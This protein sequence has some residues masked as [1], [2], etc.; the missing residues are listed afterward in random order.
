MQL[1]EIKKIGQSFAIGSEICFC[2]P[3]GNGL[4]N[5]TYLVT[6]KDKTRYTLQKI[7]TAVFQNPEGL[8]KN[9]VGVT[10]YL[11]EKIRQRGGDTTRETMNIIPCLEGGYYKVDEK[12]Q[13]W[14]MSLYIGEVQAY[15]SAERPGVLYEAARMFGRFQRDLCDYPATELFEVIPDFHHTGKRYLAFL[16]AVKKNS[17]GRADEMRE[18]IA[19]LQTYADRANL[20]VDR[21][22]DGT[23]PVRVTH[24]DT[25]LNNVLM[26]EQTGKGVCVID[27]DTVMPGSLL[28]DFGDSVRFAANHGAEDDTDLGQVWLDLDR[29]REYLAGFLAGVGDSI[30][31]EEKRLLPMSVWM[32]TY[33]GALRFATDYLNGDTYFKIK[34]PEHNLVRVRAQI[35]LMKDIE[36][37]LDTMAQIVK[38][39]G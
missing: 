28:Y 36:E 7:N 14:R 17:A 5:T 37:K 16:E 23:L 35:R 34:Y 30:T 18:E 24:N 10:A 32:M 29:Y 33:E 26:D 1:S 2:K 6:C 4:I 13:C 11:A 12:D 8:M 27:L 38:E 20:I 39:L 22:A 31:E 19:F 21:L 15:D 25:K 9:I 3:L